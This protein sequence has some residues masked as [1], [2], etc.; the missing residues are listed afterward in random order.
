[1]T[2]QYRFDDKLRVTVEGSKDT[3]AAPKETQLTLDTATADQRNLEA[4]LKANKKE[5]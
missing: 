4:W 3:E 1:M 2:G 5:E